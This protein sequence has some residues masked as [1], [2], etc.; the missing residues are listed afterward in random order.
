MRGLPFAGACKLSNMHVTKIKPAMYV[1]GEP[2]VFCNT[3]SALYMYLFTIWC[4][5]SVLTVFYFKN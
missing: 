2:Y 3:L 1:R 5:P 4:L